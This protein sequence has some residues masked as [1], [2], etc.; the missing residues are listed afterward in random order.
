MEREVGSVFEFDGIRL[1]V[2]IADKCYGCFFNSF[3]GCNSISALFG[4]CSAVERT[5]KTNV[6]FKL[7]KNE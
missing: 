2:V 1:K 5:D 4:E 3:I 7:I 6:I